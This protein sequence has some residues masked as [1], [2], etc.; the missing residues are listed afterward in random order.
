MKTS[1]WFDDVPVLGKLP[2]GR[3][4]EKLREVGEVGAAEAVE[5]AAVEGAA[6]RTFGKSAASWWPFGDKAWQHT[7]HAFG[8][9][10]PAAPGVELLPIRHA[11]NIEADA[12]LKDA[13]IKITLDRLRVADYPG[14]GTHRVLFDFYAQNQLPGN[15]E[16]LHFNATY[17]V[18]E[19]EQ[20]A[21]LG[22][23]VFVGL[24]VGAAGVAFKCF[25]VNVKN[26]EDEAFLGFLESDVFKAGLK[27][28]TTLQ[29]AIA[30]LSGMAFA[31]TKS[32]ASRH[33]NVPV[34]E[35]YLGLDFT[36]VP[37]GARLAE[38]AY[39]AVQIP[40]SLHSVWDWG[41]WVYNPASG[42]VVSQAD[43]TNLIPYNYLV[44]GVSR[45]DEL[46]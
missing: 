19:G 14:G 1:V 39:L 7:A 3:A 4:A 46:A 22:Y 6:V 36:S 27:L 23:P 30:P 11:G 42:H 10:A 29:P 18:R 33:R 15:V 20:A 28:A 32:I 12:S 40:E 44:F 25:T 31:L 8:Y 43:Q 13:R 24:N 35:F 45:Y 34:Q 41:E 16:H 37:T 17:R 5:E 21:I 2:P 38:G 26:D 9:L